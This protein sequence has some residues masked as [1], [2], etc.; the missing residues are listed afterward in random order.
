MAHGR[1]GRAHGEHV[2][3]QMVE[4]EVGGVAMVPKEVVVERL[5]L[6]ANNLVLEQLVPMVQGAKTVVVGQSVPMGELVLEASIAVEGQSVPMGE[7]GCVLVEEVSIVVEEGMVPMGLAIGLAQIRV[8]A[9]KVVV[10][11]GR[12]GI[13][14]DY[15]YILNDL[16]KIHVCLCLHPLHRC[17]RPQRRPHK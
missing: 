14:V 8:E 2:V 12:V 11:N 4:V 6:V 16:R 15:N 17:Q 9:A 3:E 1:C 5:V 10:G 7:V 13:A